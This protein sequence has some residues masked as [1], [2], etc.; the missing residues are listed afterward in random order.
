MKYMRFWV[1]FVFCVI[2][3][4]SY[5]LAQVLV[6][7]VVVDS[8]TQEGVPYAS[9]GFAWSNVL[10]MSSETGA[11]KLSVEDGRDAD[12]IIVACVGYVSRTIAVKDVGKKIELTQSIQT[13]KDVLVS[14]RHLSAKEIIERAKEGIDSIYEMSYSKRRTF[15]R[16][17]STL[18]IKNLDYTL[19]K[20]TIPEINETFMD[21]LISCVPDKTILCQEALC[22]VFGSLLT[23]TDEVKLEILKSCSISPKNDVQDVTLEFNDYV[24]KILKK[25]IKRDSYFKV[26][27]GIVGTAVGKDE[28]DLYSLFSTNKN[29]AEEEIENKREIF[30]AVIKDGIA[31]SNRRMF[32]DDD[33]DFIIE[34][35]RYEFKVEEY[36][37]LDDELVYKISFSPKGRARLSGT[38]YI[39]VNDYGVMRVEYKNV[40]PIYKISLFGIDVK[41]FCYKGV[42]MFEKSTNDKYFLR[43]ANHSD[44]VFMRA[45]RP[46]TITE[47]NKNTLGRRKQNQVSFDFDVSVVGEAKTE[48]LVFDNHT[49]LKQEYDDKQEKEFE[50]YE[51]MPKYEPS[52]WDGYNIIEPN[53][54]MEE[55]KSA[56]IE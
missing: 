15:V 33:L 43:Y 11:F 42:M 55:Y 52:F 5:G 14:D 7:S 29:E 50:G 18:E 37:V 9:V 44:A 41:V 19:K 34:S 31:G 32:L 47:K 38:V 35:N 51:Y 40:K 21:T 45:D 20:S 23:Q 53:K 28:E 36:L 4:Y 54:L 49:I 2:M 56:V 13:L 48:Y 27:S 3:L 12:S 26:R 22:D 16:R 17:T 30:V 39:N 1:S 6:N 24:E 10:T 46:L 8:A 25:R